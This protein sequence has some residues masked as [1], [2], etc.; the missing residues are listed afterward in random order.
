MKRPTRETITPQDRERRFRRTIHILQ[1][2]MCSNAEV[3]DC[4]E[5]DDDWRSSALHHSGNTR[6]RVHARAK[7]LSCSS[8]WCIAHTALRRICSNFFLLG[9]SLYP[10]PLYLL[11][12]SFV[13]VASLHE[14]LMLCNA[15]TCTPCLLPALTPSQFIITVNRYMLASQIALQMGQ[16]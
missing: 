14:V 8:S 7:I 13:V 6:A 5:E 11:L 4:E 3:Q 2:V 10:K 1:C 9:C 12:S 16:F 15:R